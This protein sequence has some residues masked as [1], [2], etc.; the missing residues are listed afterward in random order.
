MAVFT[1][2]FNKAGSSVLGPDLTW[3]KITGDA[4]VYSNKWRNVTQA[5]DVLTRAE[6]DVGSVDMYAQAYIDWT[7]WGNWSIYARMNSTTWT[8]YCLAGNNVDVEGVRLF[9]VV[10]G[11]FTLLGQAT[12]A[13]NEN[14]P[15][16]YRIEVSGGATPTIVVRVDGVQLLSV[17]DTDA[18][19]TTGQR[20]A[21][22]A[23]AAATQVQWDAFETGPLSATGGP[24]TVS[25]AV[26][27]LAIVSMMSAASATGTAN[28]ISITLQPLAIVSTMVPPAVSG[29]AAAPNTTIDD[30][31]Q[32]AIP[33]LQ[34]EIFVNLETESG[35]TLD[36]DIG[37]TPSANGY[38]IGAGLIGSLGLIPTGSFVLNGLDIITD[39]LGGSITDEGAGVVSADGSYVAAL[40][41]VAI[42]DETGQQILA[43]TLPSP[44]VFVTLQSLN[45]VSSMS[46][47]AISTVAPLPPGS[48]GIVLQPLAIFSSMGVIAQLQQ[49]TITHATP[50]APIYYTSLI[51]PQIIQDASLAG[52]TRITSRLQILNSDNTVYMNDLDVEAGTVTVSLDRDERRTIDLT[53]YDPDSVLDHYYGGLWYDKIIVPYRGITY[54][55][56]IWEAPMGRFLIDRIS[57]PDFPH[58]V[59]ISGRD[60]TK[61]LLLEKLTFATTFTA[62]QAPEDVIR[63]IATNAALTD[64][65]RLNLT[66]TGKTLGRDYTFERGTSRWEI[67]ANLAEA[68]SQEVFFDPSGYLVLRPFSDPTITPTTWLFNTG[69]STANLAS[70]TKSADDSR[71]FNHV[72]VVGE[73]TNH[74]PVTGEAKNTLPGSPTRVDLIGQ[75]TY[76]Y[77]SKFVSTQ[78]QADE[79][80]ATLLTV[81]SLESYEITFS[82]IVASWLEVGTVVTINDPEPWTGQPTQFLLTDLTIPMGLGTMSGTGKRVLKV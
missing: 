36:S 9:R 66:P 35:F 41:S 12:F 32:V 52:M 44:T 38:V 42:L 80:A 17:A 3:T 16:L 77:D 67:I 26:P 54:K 43:D 57:E 72:V 10:N 8:G 20:G 82:A 39:E 70:F 24:L 34:S 63:T 11:N 49:A 59:S 15:Y 58:V 5:A 4:E 21:L 28:N 61:R 18:P 64:P 68:F 48:V 45:I 27:T 14:T 2:S 50:G 71:L 51:P 47:F 7:S 19:I 69:S 56:H 74:L 30:E 75:R 73:S 62:A 76:P 53:I 81:M 22:G 25:V 31:G 79:L 6:H 60:E 37:G 13:T 78:A 1:E 23:Y 40:S 46:A 65:R 55:N 29:S 33:T